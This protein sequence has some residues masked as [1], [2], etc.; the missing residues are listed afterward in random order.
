M[1]IDPPFDSIFRTF[2]ETTISI[3]LSLASTALD[4]STVRIVETNS[5][6]IHNLRT[7]FIIPPFFFLY[8][9]TTYYDVFVPFQKYKLL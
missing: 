4:R 7:L 3:V 6:L 2:G 5:V 8:I 1:D 9:F